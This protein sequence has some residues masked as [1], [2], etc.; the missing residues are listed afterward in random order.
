MK[1]SV[2]IPVNNLENKILQCLNSIYVQ[3]MPKSNYEVLITF[4]SCTDNSESVVREWI[5][6]HSD[7]RLR[8]FR[9]ECKCPGSARNVGL[10]HAAGDY[11]MFVD[12]DDYL[13]NSSAM[14]ILYNA[15]Q[16]HNAVRV[17]DHGLSGRNIKFSRRLTIWLHFFSRELIGN[18]RFT[19]LLLN[20]DFEFV[21]RVRSKAGYNEAIVNIPLYFYNYDSQRMLNRIK[22]AMD[23]SWER[24]T[25]GLPPLFVGDEFIPNESD[26]VEYETLQ[27]SGVEQ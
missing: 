18:D 17:M 24:S 26:N 9:A 4:D 3:D 13:M 25:Q 12:G 16:G 8:A 15:V 21:K 11:I 20:E 23:L 10:D 14:T 2:I 22:I 27:Q 1:I 7:M 19:D 5:K 6:Q